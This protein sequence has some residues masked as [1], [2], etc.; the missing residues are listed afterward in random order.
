MM[1]KVMAIVT[2]PGKIAQFVITVIMINMVNSQ[3]TLICCSA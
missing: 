2:K 3:N 1:D